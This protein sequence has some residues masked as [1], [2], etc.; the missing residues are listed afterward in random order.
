MTN[1]LSTIQQ[2]TIKR[3]YNQDSYM[4]ILLN[5]D[6]LFSNIHLYGYKNWFDG[7]IFSG[8]DISKF[9][10]DIQLIFDYD[11]KPDIN[12]IKT[13]RK[14][15]I[16]ATMSEI[17]LLEPRKIKDPSDYREGTLKP[18]LDKHK[19]WLVTINIPRNV[20]NFD[21]SFNVNDKISQDILSQLVVKQDQKDDNDFDYSVED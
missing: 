14:H 5:I 12:G 18:K 20:I 11:E 21:D 3:L 16:K 15:N 19:C 13:L 17:N 7:E 6:E 10:I 2:E 1:I 9:W 4:T 8:P